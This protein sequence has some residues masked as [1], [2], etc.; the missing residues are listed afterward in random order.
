MGR[1][2]SLAAQR[3]RFRVAAPAAV[4][5]V[6]L[7]AVLLQ[8][9][10]SASFREGA[11]ALGLMAAGTTTGVSV[12]LR[13]RWSTGR[14]RRGW[15]W[16]L[17]AAVCAV[18]GNVWAAIAGYDPVTD[19]SLVSDLSVSLALALSIVGLLTF[20]TARRRGRNLT[21]MVLDGIVGGSAVLIMASVL[22]YDE[23]LAS[24]DQ[25]FG[26]EFFS[27]LIPFLDVALVTFGLFLVLRSRGESRPALA[28]VALG[29]LLYAIADLSFA[30]RVAQGTFTWGDF[31]DLGWIAGYLLIAVASWYPAGDEDEEVEDAHTAADARDTLLVFSV[32]GVA[33]IVQIFFSGGEE[34]QRAQEVL[35]LTLAVATGARQVLLTADNAQL[36][37][38]LERRVAEQTADLRRLA[39]R[40]E[41]LLTS[42]GDGIYGVDA[43][44]R[45]TSM[46]PSGARALGYTPEALLGQPAHEL[47]HA[48]GVDG[49]P[50]PYE[51]CYI[52][53]A[54]ASGTVTSAEEDVYVCADGAEFPVEIT[55]S[56][57]V[58]DD[59]VTGAVVVFRDVTQR[60]EVDR[61]K[62]EFLSVVSHELRTPLTSIRGSLGLLAG[63][64]LGELSPRATSMARIALESSE[65]LTRLINDILDLERIESG[66]RPMELAVIDARALVEAATAELDAMA[67]GADVRLEVGDTAG[68]VLADRDRIVQTLINLLNNAIKFSSAGG[69]VVVDAQPRDGGTVLF[70]VH[71]EGRGIPADQI[72]TIFD[73]FHQVDSSDARQKGGTGLGLAI[74]RGIVDRHGGRI[75]AES[76]PGRSTTV[77]F[78]LPAPHRSR[79]AGEAVPADAPTIL[80]CDDEPAVVGTLSAMLAQHGYRPVGVGDG[81]EAIARATAERPAAVLLDLRMS[82]TSGAEVLAELRRGERT[83]NIPVV[84]VS[85]LA[86][87]SD[88]ELSP[89]ADGWLVKPV[90][91][92][93]LVQAVEVALAGRLSESAVLLVEDD[94]DLAEVISALLHAH[95]LRVDHATT[96]ASAIETGRAVRPQVIV[97][98]LHLPDDDGSA[99]VA[100]FRRDPALAATPLVVYSAADVEVER[101][102]S[103]EL[104]PTVFLTKGRTAPED[105]EQRVLGLLDAVTGRPAEARVPTS[106]TTTSTTTTG[107]TTTTTSRTA[108]DTIPKEER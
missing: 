52:A 94:E 103:L 43:R 107:T 8:P 11:S 93:Q 67:R 79:L 31:P 65:R 57:L 77:Q 48:P 90:T 99:V 88:P 51:G 58:D 50:F 35:W 16:L 73:R 61:M 2:L 66:A 9:G 37:R 44:G 98:D 80:V 64:Q 46:N 82:G 26:P 18:L 69:R 5:T 91:E 101:R 70:R 17:A 97:L 24:V 49:V 78:T 84:V 19:P 86:P 29:F 104:G 40:T 105:L 92:G 87:E 72:G 45:I 41:T 74:S 76:E 60:R 20:P 7:F 47:F 30:V 59:V 102:A 108:S 85:G 96:A 28:L 12:W 4:L 36:R 13:A 14:R 25:V 95:G 21:I 22:V 71:D 38:G 42:V 1:S 10:F 33:G 32:V 106:P 23:L 62:N 15:L 89:Q 6:G 39:R 55:A 81:D 100:A 53:E 54:I 34:M 27:L 75:W 56:P 68:T 63:G 3:R 83:R